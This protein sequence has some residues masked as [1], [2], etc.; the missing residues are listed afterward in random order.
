MQ[1][2]PHKRMYPY[3]AVLF[4]LDGT[5]LDTLEDLTD[6]VNHTLR[7]FGY[8]TF[9]PAGVRAIVGNGVRKLIERVLPGGAADPAMEAA[10]EEFKRYYTGHC[11]VR[12]HPYDGILEAL[13]ALREAGI[14]LAI[15]SNKNEEAVQRLAQ[16]YFGT[17]VSAVVGGREG[18]PRKPSPDMPLLALSAI[19]AEPERTL[20][21]GD[22]DVDLITAQSAGMDCMLVSWGFRERAALAALNPRYLADDPAEIPALVL[23][24]DEAPE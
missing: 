8:P 5:L 10:L 20:F 12:T 7:R 11:N 13:T 19:R 3:E 6:A 9:E 24:P 16:H 17:L 22:S 21:V 1:T 2:K 18:V 15:V 23:Q 14:R 4:D